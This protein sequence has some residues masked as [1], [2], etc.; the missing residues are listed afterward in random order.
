MAQINKN[1]IISIT[2]GKATGFSRIRF[3]IPEEMKFTF[4]L[5]DLFKMDV[6]GFE[7]ETINFK[8]E[9]NKHLVLMNAKIV[10]SK[11]MT[12]TFTFAVHWDSYDSLKTLL[13]KE[14]L[15]SD[16]EDLA[17]IQIKKI[18]ETYPPIIQII[19]KMN[20]QQ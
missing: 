9:Q 10:R 20:L 7:I 19:P 14:I 17:L 11:L 6:I 4:P 8:E 16:D 15:T 1:A 3:N 13:K 18:I 2:Q 12:A 5:S